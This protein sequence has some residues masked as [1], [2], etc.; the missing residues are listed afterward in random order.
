MNAIVVDDEVLTA[1]YMY[2]L[3]KNEGVNVLGYYTNPYEALEMI[4]K[5]KLDVIFLDVEMPGINGV[6]MAEKI[7]G[8]GYE[9]EIV[10]TTAYKQYA[11]EAFEVNA[12]DYLLKP[13]MAKD[14]KRSVERIKKRKSLNYNNSAENINK[15]IIV[16]LFGS[17]CLYEEGQSKSIRWITNKCAELF[18]FMLLQKDAK[19]VSKWRIIEALW[20]EKDSEKGD[21]NLRS[22]VSRLNKTLRENSIGILLISTGNGYKLELKDINIEVDVF[23]LENL[24][25]NSIKINDDNVNCY[26]KI[27]LGYN[28]MLLNEF[29]GQWC[30]EFRETYHRYF[31]AGAKRLINYYE[32]INEESIKFLKIIELMIKFEPYDEKLRQYVL[33]L[34]YNIG[35][36]KSLKKY[37]EEYV[38]LLKTDLGIQPSDSISNLYKNILLGMPYR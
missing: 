13:I 16:N 25:L 8:D 10:F 37:Y 19:E 11:V 5:I 14:I 3:L 24:I 23:N 1:E 26:E 36:I 29:S 4:N 21:V 22:T 15:K 33:K 35:G 28:E 9:S 30:Y 2:K 27:I 7:R 31:I 17:I 18:S 34:H 12:I 32:E 6:D 38:K 20:P